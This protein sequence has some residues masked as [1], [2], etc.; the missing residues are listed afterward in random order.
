MRNNRDEGENCQSQKQQHTQDDAHAKETVASHETGL[1]WR[2]Q[3]KSNERQAEISRR[4]LLMLAG[5][6]CEDQQ[7]VPAITNHL[8]T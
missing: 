6:K 4:A 1:C 2:A 8:C 5:L 7:G 3:D